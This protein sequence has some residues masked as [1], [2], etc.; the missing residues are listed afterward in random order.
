MVFNSHPETNFT[1]SFR[2]YFLNECIDKILKSD[3]N[4][5]CENTIGG[6]MCKCKAGFFGS[7]ESCSDENECRDP[8][9]CPGE[10]MQCINTLG[11]A[12]CVCKAGYQQ[13][14]DSCYPAA[15]RGACAAAN[16]GANAE[17]IAFGKNAQCVCKNG[18]KVSLIIPTW[19]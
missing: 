2:I 11:S 1:L 12:K 15:V 19:K 6:H 17:C 13:N 7:G 8:S 16:C 4:A 5:E 9:F 14:G 10:N 18:Y 3:E